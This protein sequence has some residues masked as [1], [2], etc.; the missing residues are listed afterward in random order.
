MNKELIDK[1]KTITKKIENPIIK[2]LLIE[3]I[4]TIEEQREKITNLEQE[5]EDLKITKAGQHTSIEILKEENENLKE[6]AVL[7]KDTL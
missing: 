4:D 1:F 5:N 2:N 6:I 7:R 3:M